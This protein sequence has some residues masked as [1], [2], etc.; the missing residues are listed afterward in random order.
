VGAGAVRHCVLTHESVL[1]ALICI[2]PAEHDAENRQAENRQAEYSV[3][4]PASGP[5]TRSGDMI[6]VDLDRTRRHAAAVLVHWPLRPT[7]AAA[8]HYPAE[9]AA[10]VR[11]IAESATA[12]P[13]HKAGG[14]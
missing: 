11:I 13:R 9:A 7:T 3:P 14:I 1:I 4:M 6:T 5:I 8:T 12:L 10:I 2:R